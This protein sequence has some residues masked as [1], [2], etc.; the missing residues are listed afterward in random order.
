MD[1]VLHPEPED[2][3]YESFTSQLPTHKNSAQSLHRRSRQVCDPYIAHP[4]PR[5][6][7]R[8][9]VATP[10]TVHPPTPCPPLPSNPNRRAFEV[11]PHIPFRPP[12]FKTCPASEKAHDRKATKGAHDAKVGKLNRERQQLKLPMIYS[13]QSGN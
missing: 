1:S 5:W 13:N 11:N 6:L 4:F 8:D 2:L 10:L 3:H 12:G 7:K 9:P